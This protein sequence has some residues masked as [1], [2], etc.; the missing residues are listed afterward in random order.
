MKVCKT[1]ND[2][3]GKCILY[4]DTFRAVDYYSPCPSCRKKDSDKEHTLRYGF[5]L[6]KKV[7]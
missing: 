4:Y 6:A 7:V 2:E 5:L 3:F 1:C